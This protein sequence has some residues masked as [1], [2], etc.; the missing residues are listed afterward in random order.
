MPKKK[1]TLKQKLDEIE[2]KYQRSL[3][4]YQNLV[5]QTTKEKQEFAKYS[6]DALI[7]QLLPLID[8][9]EQAASHLDDDGLDMIVSQFHQL[10]TSEGIEPIN[11]QPGDA[12]DH[13]LHECLETVEDSSQKQNTLAQIDL[14]GY[15]YSHGRVIRPAKVTV[16][17]ST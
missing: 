11:P 17:K 1:P 6:T 2:Q 13:T 15:K 8:N 16:Y 4:D 10:L 9:L 12:F 3:A 14:K 7:S 5:K